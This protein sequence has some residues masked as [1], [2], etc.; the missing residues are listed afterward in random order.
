LHRA[1]QLL[2]DQLDK[3]TGPVLLNTFAFAGRRCQRVI[4]AVLTR[5]GIAE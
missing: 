2:R 1:R 3:Q 4:A 5:L